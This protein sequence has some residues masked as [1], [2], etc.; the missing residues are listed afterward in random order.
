MCRAPGPVL[1]AIVVAGGTGSIGLPTLV[2]TA[3]FAI[4]TALPLLVFA[5]AGAAVSPN[6]SPHS[7]VGSGQYRSPAESR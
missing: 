2:L 6:V 4:G 1:A 5:L 3:T 7:A